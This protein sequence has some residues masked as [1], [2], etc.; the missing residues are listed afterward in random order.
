MVAPEDFLIFL[1]FKG[2]AEGVSATGCTCRAYTDLFCGT[3]TISVMIITVFY[4]TT[5]S[6]IV[7][8]FTSAFLVLVLILLP[9]YTSLFLINLDKEP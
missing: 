2:C 5:D 8:L 6:L 4:I 3:I 7:I 9:I 1:V